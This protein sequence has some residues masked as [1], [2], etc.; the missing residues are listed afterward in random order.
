MKKGFLLF[1]GISLIIAIEVTSCKKDYTC[2]CIVKDSSG[3]VV[4]TLSTS[5]TL[6]TTKK[7]AEDACTVSVV[8]SGYTE[9]CEVK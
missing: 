5:A 4:S 1:S 2:E 3:A 9:T 6:H 8:T 7:K